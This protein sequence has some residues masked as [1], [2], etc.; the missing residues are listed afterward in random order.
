[1]IKISTYTFFFLLFSLLNAC[2]PSQNTLVF[3]KVPTTDMR[4]AGKPINW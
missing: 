2:S 4:D 3:E 1:M